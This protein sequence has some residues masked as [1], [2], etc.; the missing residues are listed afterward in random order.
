MAEE[1]NSVRMGRPPL[2]PG[3]RRSE[4]LSVRVTP[5]ERRMLKEEARRRNST[6]SELL[7]EPWRRQ[8]EGTS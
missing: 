8:R 2:P 7:M 4:I 1:Q 5:G 6:V 3:K